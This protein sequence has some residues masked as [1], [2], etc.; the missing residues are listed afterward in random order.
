MSH[1]STIQTIVNDLDALKQAADY[2]GLEF[3]EGQRT[4]KWY[5][6]WVRDYHEEDAAY[7]QGHN[8][9]DYGKCDHALRV[10]G[11]DN[12]YEVGVV[13]KG[14]GTYSLLFDHWAGG[15]GL[16]EK[17]GAK[18]SKLNQTYTFL[19]VETELKHR[20]FKVVNL[21]NLSNGSIKMT[22]QGPVKL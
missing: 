21:E 19:K 14:D 5:G 17:I 22:M 12:A 8:P 2:L 6:S 15:N 4:F 9:E 3:V 16:M 20:G 1:V 13:G 11:N 10:K 18:G 7:K